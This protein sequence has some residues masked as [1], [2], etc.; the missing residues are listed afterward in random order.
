MC[1]SQQ[2]GNVH[3][4]KDT[5]PNRRGGFENPS[6]GQPKLLQKGGGAV[7]KQGRAAGP[8]GGARMGS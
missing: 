2:A 1:V 5:V 8:T 6:K 4:V 3:S 7:P